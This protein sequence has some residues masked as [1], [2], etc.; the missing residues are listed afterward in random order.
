MEPLAAAPDGL[1]TSRRALLAAG[2]GAVLVGATGC[3]V[4]NPLHRAAHTP[5]AQAVR[6]LAPDV[7]IAVQAVAAIRA[8]DAAVA[9]A[10]AADPA[11][12]ARVTPFRALHAAHLAAV[13]DAVPAGVDTSPTGAPTGGTAAPTRTGGLATVRH[14]E[15]ELHGTLVAL[16]MRAQSGLFARLLG[17]MAAAISQRA[18]V[19]FR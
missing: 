10:L 17:S 6:D 3:T 14:A 11:L 18:A 13:S 16:A 5:A 7:A 9:A 2:A 1:V 4:D 8:T 15:T 19:A 12:A